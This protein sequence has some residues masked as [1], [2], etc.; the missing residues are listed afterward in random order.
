MTT[1]KRRLKGENGRLQ[2]EK[3]ATRGCNEKNSFQSKPLPGSNSVT[4]NLRCRLYVARVELSMKIQTRKHT[5]HWTFRMEIHRK[6]INKMLS[7]R[8]RYQEKQL[9][10]GGLLLTSKIPH[11]ALEFYER[12]S[13]RTQRVFFYSITLIQFLIY[14]KN[15]SSFESS[16]VRA[17]ERYKEESDEKREKG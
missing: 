13:M 16:R 1:R 17:G 11:H 6:L 4:P 5:C 10:R 9:E 12:S 7:T 8:F 14:S 2:G 3:M 15:S